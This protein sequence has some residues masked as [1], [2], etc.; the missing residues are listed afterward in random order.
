[1]PDSRDAALELPVARRAAAALYRFSIVC[2][3][4]IC[5]P[6]LV[7]VRHIKRSENAT[8]N[9]C[10]EGQKL[11]PWLRCGCSGGCAL[12]R[13]TMPS[14][15]VVVALRV[16]PYREKLR[17]NPQKLR[18]AVA[19]DSQR[20]THTTASDGRMSPSLFPRFTCLDTL[21]LW[22]SSSW[23]ISAFLRPSFA[24]PQTRS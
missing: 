4:A 10:I 8:P 17:S 15:A 11:R 7:R 18:V 13:I 21:D 6:L 24:N 19:R 1:M 20:A 3:L 5:V 12:N 14:R 9:H 22:I 2:L 23:A 16:A